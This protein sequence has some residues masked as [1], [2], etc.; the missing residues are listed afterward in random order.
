M[1]DTLTQDQIDSLLGGGTD[2]DDIGDINDILNVLAEPDAPSTPDVIAGFDFLD[3]P[4]DL[5]TNAPASHSGKVLPMI[6]TPSP[7]VYNVTPAGTRIPI[8]RGMFARYCVNC[9]VSSFQSITHCINCGGQ[10]YKKSN[11]SLF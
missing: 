6:G 1:A 7:L 8:P 9:G 10:F 11:L 3:T 5:S 2:T 4:T